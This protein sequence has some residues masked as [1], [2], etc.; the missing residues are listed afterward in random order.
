MSANKI[1]EGI[2]LRY[3]QAKLALSSTPG[4]MYR[5]RHEDSCWRAQ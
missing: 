3:L 1:Y 2:A 5:R 4:E